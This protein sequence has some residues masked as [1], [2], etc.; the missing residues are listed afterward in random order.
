[1]T[2]HLSCLIIKL[3]YILLSQ[4]TTYMRFNAVKF[5]YAVED[6]HNYRLRCRT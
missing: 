1:M 3:I 5:C 6:M 2:N 4:I